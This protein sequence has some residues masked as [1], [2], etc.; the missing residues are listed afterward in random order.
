MEAILDL[1]QCEDTL[2]AVRFA[3]VYLIVWYGLTLAL[4]RVKAASAPGLKGQEKQVAYLL[5]GTI[6]IAL[7]CW[8]GVKNA[9]VLFGPQDPEFRLLTAIPAALSVCHQQLAYQIYAVIGGII[10]G[11]PL[12]APS[13]FLHHF[14]AG[15]CGL[16][17]F[18]PFIQFYSI[19]FGGIVELSN[20]P[21]TWIDVAKTVPSLK[22]A[23]PGMYSGAR[24]CF[25]LLFVLLRNI[26]W[27]YF[28]GLM[29]RDV[30]ILRDRVHPAGQIFLYFAAAALT[31]LQV[32]WGYVVMRNVLRAV[33]KQA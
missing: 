16:F 12:N 5:T 29:C 28:A 19:F 13:M 9:A 2:T 24:I 10:V 7:L 21:L 31:G 1:A 11:P 18:L 25:A 23:Y 22:K 6:P 27:P 33:K 20:I 14:S 30:Y 8:G 32:N 15:F 26:M 4:R 3:G 17:S